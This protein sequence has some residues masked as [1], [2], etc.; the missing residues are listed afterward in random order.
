MPIRVIGG[1][2][3]LGVTGES[4]WLIKADRSMKD[5]HGASGMESSIFQW[6]RSTVKS[7]K[8]GIRHKWTLELKAKGY[9]ARKGTALEVRRLRRIVDRYELDGFT[10]R[11]FDL[12]NP[13]ITGCLALGILN[14][15]GIWAPARRQPF[16]VSMKCRG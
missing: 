5:A 15:E 14:A 11:C 6:M 10:L 16:A 12:L 9:D 13:F 1:G 7:T 2:H 4:D 3:A 8:N